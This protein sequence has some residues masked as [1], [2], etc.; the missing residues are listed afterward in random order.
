[1]YSKQQLHIIKRKQ[2]N[3]VYEKVGRLNAIIANQEEEI[4]A[5]KEI[6]EIRDNHIKDLDKINDDY[7]KKINEIIGDYHD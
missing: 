3:E 7:R 5:L 2:E 6:N 4:K 1:M